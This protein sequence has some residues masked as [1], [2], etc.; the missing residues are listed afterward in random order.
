MLKPVGVVVHAGG[1]LLAQP[2]FGSSVLLLG[3]TACMLVL[4]GAPVRI[5]AL[6]MLLMLPALVLL[7]VFEPLPHAPRDLVHGSVAGPAGRGLPAQQR[8][9]GDRPR[10]MVR[11]GLGASVQK[12]NYLPEAHTDSSSR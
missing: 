6:P 12:L 8:A 4:G 2:D 11:R 5:I 3:I 1:L 7:V 10:R 9:D